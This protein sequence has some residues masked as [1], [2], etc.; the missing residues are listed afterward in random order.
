MPRSNS[1]AKILLGSIA[2]ALP[3]MAFAKDRDVKLVFCVPEAGGS[4][5]LQRYKPLIDPRAKT[6]FAEM[7][8]ADHQLLELRLRR[9]SP[10]SE[11]VFDYKFDAT[12][13]LN[14]LEGSVKVFGSWEGE[15]NLL[16]DADGTV[17]PY[18]IVYRQNYAQVRKPDDAA[19]YI[20][21]LK[22]APIYQTVQAVPCAAMMK[23]AEGMNA[24]QE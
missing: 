14:A 5:S 18:Q 19:D 12:G 3:S 6:V 16:P 20:S 21:L 1:I 15:A 4:W 24:T 22:D 13:R 11:V 2:M 8:F 10:R 17:P 7:S 9:F 23:E